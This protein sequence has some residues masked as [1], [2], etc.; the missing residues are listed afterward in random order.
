MTATDDD[1]TV[2]VTVKREELDAVADRLGTRSDAETVL[3]SVHGA[4]ALTELVTA[5]LRFGR[6]AAADDVGRQTLQIRAMLDDLAPDPPSRGL[7]LSA[8]SATRPAG[9]RRRR[10]VP[11][12]E[13]MAE[14]EGLRPLDP[15]R[16]RADI[17]DGFDIEPDDPYKRA[18]G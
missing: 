2:T 5:A 8:L 1:V 11:T 14:F 17:D 3:A 6:L 16:F 10:A 7:L 12:S 4:G 13:F 15:E 9:G 18:Q